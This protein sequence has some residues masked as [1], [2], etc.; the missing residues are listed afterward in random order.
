MKCSSNGE[1]H[2]IKNSAKENQ[3]GKNIWPD[4]ER[5]TPQKKR[6][7]RKKGGNRTKVYHTEKIYSLVPL[8]GPLVAKPQKKSTRHFVWTDSYGIPFQS[9]QTTPTFADFAFFA[10]MATLKCK[11]EGQVTRAASKCHSF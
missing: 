1:S 3:Q 8:S 2:Q 4:V 11:L 9:G 6:T 5:C 7:E 10:L